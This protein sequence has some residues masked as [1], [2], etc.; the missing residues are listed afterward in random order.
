MNNVEFPTY[1]QVTPSFEDVLKFIDKT[2]L[3]Q[4]LWQLPKAKT[5]TELQK[6][7]TILNQQILYSKSND[8]IVPKISY[9]FFKSKRIENGTLISPEDNP[10]LIIARNGIRFDFPRDRTEPHF[11]LA[12]CFEEFITVALVT[13]G[14]RPLEFGTKLYSE[15]NFSKMFY[16]RGF[17][18]AS[19]EATI[20][21]AT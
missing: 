14:G 13:V 2:F 21:Y 5:D 4:R 7:E 6:Y 20:E 19:A 15:G 9:G 3:F 8:I 11:C 12:D 18:T 10:G 17:A 16:L 1:N